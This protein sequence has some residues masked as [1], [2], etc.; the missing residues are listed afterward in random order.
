MAYAPVRITP[1]ALGLQRHKRQQWLDTTFLPEY[2]HSVAS[3]LRLGLA[4]G[5]TSA[6][7]INQVLQAG[8]IVTHANAVLEYICEQLNAKARAIYPDIEDY[9]AVPV[10]SCLGTDNMELPLGGIEIGVN[11]VIPVNFP[12]DTIPSS[13]AV[14]LSVALDLL[15]RFIPMLRDDD[16][17]GFCWW[18]EERLDDFRELR[19]RRLLDDDNA[20]RFAEQLEAYPGL[21]HLIHE[22]EPDTL[23]ELAR[24]WSAPVPAWLDEYRQ[25]RFR[26]DQERASTLIHWLWAWRSTAPA[27]YRHPVARFIFRVAR[28][29]RRRCRKSRR[30]NLPHGYLAFLQPDDAHSLHLATLIMSNRP[31]S[32]DVIDTIYQGIAEADE[33]IVG[34]LPRE[35]AT[36]KGREILMNMATGYALAAW[37][38]D[39]CP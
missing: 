18:I 28:L 26:S 20:V 3:L 5:V 13:L 1:S 31:W 12:M 30:A 23:L 8:G 37:L 11:A 15:E 7:D 34:I 17:R 32:T 25:L 38:S 35:L 2:G 14:A 36:R 24:N 19:A 39:I 33:T 21:N 10:L 9:S 27:I 16:A 29:A 6:N 4:F 22:Y